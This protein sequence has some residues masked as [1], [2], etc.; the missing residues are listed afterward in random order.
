ML[1]IMGLKFQVF[2]C[3]VNENINMQ[4]PHD[5]VME[6][7]MLKARAAA[8]KL[9]EDVLIIGA[10]TVVY[11]NGILGKPK[12]RK[13]AFNMIKYL[14]GREHEVYTGVALFSRGEDI[15][16]A[17]YERT[18]VKIKKMSDYEIEWYLDRNEYKDKAGAYGIQGAAS[19]FIEY[20]HGCYFNVVGLPVSKLYDMLKEINVSG[21][22]PLEL[23]GLMG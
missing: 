15:C 13:D 12:D 22:L 11:K 21:K 19:I 4:C 8:Q 6:L 10:D 2:Q 3:S 14:Q 7:A 23:D 18:I 16:K 5:Y 1:A 17:G 9:P 20:I